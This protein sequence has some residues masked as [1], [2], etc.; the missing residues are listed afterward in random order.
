MKNEK[1]AIVWLRRD[2]R[3]Y[4]NMA[5][6]AAVASG[7]RLLPVFVFDTEI[8][9][10]LPSKE[11]RRLEF[12]L[13]NL[14]RVEKELREKDLGKRVFEVSKQLPILHFYGKPIEAFEWILA[15]V[16]G[17]SWWKELS[18]KDNLEE[19]GE[20]GGLYFN[21]DYE[22]YAV[23]RDYE[24]ERMFKERGINVYKFNDQMVFS[25]D[26]SRIRKHDGN[27]YTI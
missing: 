14:R 4:D 24:I 27:P 15:G 10:K 22:S 8:L 7:M 2:L 3:V 16:S 5:L 1:I 11:D 25:P 18:G 21:E 26:D 17:H 9:E 6:E 12:I 20:I 19:M 13:R 23:K